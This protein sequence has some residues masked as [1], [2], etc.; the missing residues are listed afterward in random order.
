MPHIDVPVE[1]LRFGHTRRTDRWWIQPL[2]VF[3]IL[4]AFVVWTTFRA[5]ENAYFEFEGVLSPFYSPKLYDVRPSWVPSWLPLTPALLI[6]PFPA[7]FRLTCYY[8]RGAYYKAFWADPVA[9]AVGEPRETYRGE[10][11]LPLSVQNVHRY[12]MYAA[13]V[14]LVFLSYDVYEGFF[15]WHDG[16]HV[17]ISSLLLLLNVVLLAGY[18]FGCHSFRHLVGGI[19]DIMTGHPMRKKA[20][21]CSTFLNERHMR[22]AWM[23][24]FGVVIC[25]LWIRCVASGSISLATDR[26]F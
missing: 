16:F 8:Y 5:F 20:Y 14:F 24:L 9:C 1:R 17:H 23:S 15:G 19:K 13:L 7:G 10:A 6:L 25:D 4:T 11:K 22:F 21:D 2:V 18:A 12:F 26:I 3:T